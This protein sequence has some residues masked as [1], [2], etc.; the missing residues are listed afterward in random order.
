MAL[1]WGLKEFDG[2]SKHCPIT[3]YSGSN[4]ANPGSSAVIKVW[5]KVKVIFGVEEDFPTSASYM[6]RVEV[7]AVKAAAVADGSINTDLP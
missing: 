2:A 6:Y 4:A 3:L 5:N 7:L 1:F